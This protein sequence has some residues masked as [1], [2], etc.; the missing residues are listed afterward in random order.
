MAP[1]SNRR[2]P[3]VLANR[4]LRLTLI[5]VIILFNGCSVY[6]S[7]LVSNN[8]S[9]TSDSPALADASPNPKNISRAV[10][11][12]PNLDNSDMGDGSC[13]V[14]SCQLDHAQAKCQMGACVVASCEPGFGDCDNR[15]DNGCETPIN[16]VEH[17]SECDHLCQLDHA[18]S[19]CDTQQCVVEQCENGWRD[20]DLV[21]ENGC[22]YDKNL[23]DC[24][25]LS[26]RFLPGVGD[27]KWLRLQFIIQNHSPADISISDVTLRYYFTVDSEL[28]EQYSECWHPDD[29]ED[30][31][32]GFC[33]D[34]NV[35]VR[36]ETTSGTDADYYVEISFKGGMII[37][38][39]G[40]TEVLSI[41]VHKST[42]D[43]YDYTNDYSY[44]CIT[45]YT[46]TKF[47]TL[48]HQ[49]VLVWGIEPK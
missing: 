29:E 49:G 24:P 6:D 17:C 4:F 42:W 15:Y 37:P 43:V 21:V 3:I 36:V 22:E 39:A 11:Y 33:C 47:I 27:T 12:S 26:V 30:C 5:I 35:V 20:C 32:A 7:S 18:V 9:I 38:P 48:Y 28:A 41:G 44:S 25:V 23:G 31:D 45:E 8:D 46:S 10:A 19:S 14:T 34:E 40:Q 2:L 13:D 1:L 16:T